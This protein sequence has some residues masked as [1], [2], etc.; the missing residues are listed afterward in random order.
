MVEVKALVPGMILEEE[1]QSPDGKI[2]LGQ[3]TVLTSHWIGR[4]TS[5]GYKK[6]S[7]KREKPNG[8]DLE[9]L[10]AMLETVLKDTQQL[11]TPEQLE[12]E[13]YRMICEQVEIEVRR[14][15]LWTRCSGKLAPL[16]DFCRL[17]AGLHQVL[18]IPRVFLLLH[19]AS[20]EENYLYRHSL[21]VAILSGLIGRWLG[22]AEEQ[23]QQLVLAGLLHDM[24]KAKVQFEV[25]T[26]PDKLDSQETLLAR[27]HS[28]HST[29]LLREAQCEETIVRAV[30]E[31]HERLDGSGYPA[32]LEA[33]Q[34]HPYARI[35]AVADVYSALTSDRYYKKAITPLA[36]TEILYAETGKL[37]E[38]VVS[39]LINEVRR[40]LIGGKVL[41]NDGVKGEIAEFP[42]LPLTRPVIKV[43][44]GRQLDLTQYP[45]L[46]I[47]KIVVS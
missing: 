15:F 5:W 1:L 27:S 17:A 42:P 25:L 20:R 8:I 12:Q 24:G 2:L 46:G 34:I 45:D 38:A 3:G 40:H 28:F 11:K 39:C 43:I 44:D 30:G 6:I 18:A 10:Q 33:E 47:T 32:A 36:A 22:Y 19:S 14:M 29:V 31:H 13:Q 35:L 16:E 7:A 37:D 4:I 23:V 26:K 21:D 9:E 41:L